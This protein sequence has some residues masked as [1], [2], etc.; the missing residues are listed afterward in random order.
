MGEI[1][2]QIYGILFQPAVALREICHTRPLKHAVA[3]IV[4]ATV[5]TTWAGY[6]A[7]LSNGMIVIVSIAF[8]LVAWF[9]N[10]A[11]IHLMAEL[12]G[13]NGQATGLLTANGYTQVLRIFSVPIIVLASL[14]PA[15]WKL[16][17]I[18]L[19]STAIVIWEAVL[20][21]IAIRENYNL[22]TGRAVLALVLP[23]GVILGSIFISVVV[24]AGVFIQLLGK[25]GLGGV[26]P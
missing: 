11:I 13:G 6:F 9:L 25:S 2:E 14:M 15:Q 4:A 19:G 7:V 18:A 10:C 23:F 21:V 8:T 17:L 1:L 22:S 12:L 3:I 24:T 26:M 20:T 16:D 5:F